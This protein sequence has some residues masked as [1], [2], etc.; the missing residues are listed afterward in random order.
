MDFPQSRVER[1]PNFFGDLSSEMSGENDPIV[2]GFSAV[3]PRPILHIIDRPWFIRSNETNLHR[4]FIETVTLLSKG[5]DKVC[6]C[7]IILVAS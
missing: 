4:N 5:S 1:F 7:P 2:H 3:T 6:K